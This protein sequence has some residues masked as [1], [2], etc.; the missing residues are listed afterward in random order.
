V[1]YSKLKD[2]TLIHLITR[3]QPEALTELYDRYHRLVFG[4]ALQVVGERAAA[5][6][7]TLDVFTRVWEKA[8]T[9]RAEQ[10][11]VSTWLGTITRYQ[12]IDRRRRQNSR[13]DQQGLSWNELAH[14]SSLD[15]N[16]PEE[17]TALRLQQER[18]QAAV[19]QLPVEQ[20]QVL[21][22]A[23]FRG[24]THRQIAE[25]LD[26]PVGTVKT[27]LRLALQKLRRLLMEE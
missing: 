16:T 3:A 17:M 14:H 9:Y 24:Y 25:L 6:E 26:Q 21:A 23:Y 27:R 19:A 4:L 18:V 1:D 13:P 12:A 20:K 11:Q 22:L 8:I 2:E 5:E 7:I 10:A 15:D